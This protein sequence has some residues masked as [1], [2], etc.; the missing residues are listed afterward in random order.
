MQ[1]VDSGN[2]RNIA[3]V[4]HSGTGKTSLVESIMFTAGAT[5]RIGA[6]ADGTTVSDYDPEEIKR[7][8]SINLSLLPC[9]WKNTKLNFID[10]PG[11]FDFIGE[12]KAALRVTES[13]IIAVSGVSGV[14]VG[15]EQIWTHLRK[16]NTPCFIFVNKMD[17]ENIV[18]QDVVKN[19]QEKLS[20]KCIPL[21]LPIGTQ[22]DF[23]GTVDLITKK[24]MDSADKEL[25]VPEGMAA[26]ISSYREQL[27][28]AIIE[29][30]DDLLSKYLDGAQIGDDDIY[31]CLREA[32]RKGLVFPIFFGSALNNTG[33]KPML[34]AASDYFPSPVDVGAIK[35]VNTTKNAEE[36]IKPSASSPLVVFV[37]KTFTDARIGRISYIRVFSGTITSNSQVWNVNKGS[38]ERIGQLFSL[39]G[40][41]QETVTQLVAGDI[42]AV[43]KLSVTTTNDTLGTKD[44]PLKLDS[45]EFPVSAL[46]MAI[47]PKSRD[48][49][50]K[51]STA[52][53]KICEEDLTITVHRDADLGDLIISGMGETHLAVAAE[54]LHQRFG[55]A[56]T[57][58]APKIAYKE[59]ITSPVKAE[60]KHKKQSGGH[61]QYGHVLIELEPMTRS[62]GFEFVNKVVGGAIPKNYI[63]AVEKG[64]AEGIND[65]VL[66]GYPVVDIRVILY[67]GS[68]HPVDSSEMAFKIA[69]A[70]ALK[71]GLTDGRSVLLE[72]IINLG[73][74]APD[75]FTGD[76]ISDLNTKR[77][78]V[79]GMNPSGDGMNLIEAQVPEAEISRYAIDLRSITHGR[80]TFTTK[81]S[82]YE[83]VPALVAQKVIAQK[84]TATRQG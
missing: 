37:F 41:T 27:I 72:P 7:N 47:L 13:A 38:L 61:G 46:N 3:L 39:R 60:F 79:L 44:H 32:I 31:R 63:P 12:T 59:T 50:D 15:T 2:I 17:R 26:D 57:L 42:G 11:Y 45:I 19:I 66:G 18:Y 40:K 30:D 69:T 54:R 36:V 78:R 53:P 10:A 51:M 77:G 48:D 22:K 56:V 16:A 4:S 67:D 5:T 83:E 64:I 74:S 24:G 52:L 82:H 80:G 25:S 20:S 62:G 35:A 1:Q 28:E 68:F 6:I 21:V 43:A 9:Q 8:I 75:S 49:L 76:I 14:E 70:Q 34:D 71:K 33:I 81:F 23:Q 29:V 55:V 84:E 58:D 73:V 65:G